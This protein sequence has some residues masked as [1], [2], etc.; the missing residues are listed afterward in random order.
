MSMTFLGR[1]KG[2]Y[3]GRDIVRCVGFYAKKKKKKSEWGQV[4]QSDGEGRGKREKGQ[5]SQGKRCCGLTAA[6][7]SC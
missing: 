1:E 6:G 4:D 5:E 2:W 3:K 7:E